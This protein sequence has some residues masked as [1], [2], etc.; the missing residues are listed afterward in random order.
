MNNELFENLRKKKDDA[1]NRENALEINK[2]WLPELKRTGR[3]DIADA[4]IT[5]VEDC[6]KSK[7]DSAF[8]ELLQNLNSLKN[9]VSLLYTEGDSL[10]ADIGAYIS[11]ITSN[12]KE[13]TKYSREINR[14]DA[15]DLLRMD[16]YK[17]ISNYISGTKHYIEHNLYKFRK[18]K[19]K[20]F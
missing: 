6:L 2:A 5:C 13:I 11:V 12:L 18:Y 14:Q 17:E 8:Y 1:G 3:E 15:D 16:C 20:I 19:P 9:K 10:C 7:K 4:V